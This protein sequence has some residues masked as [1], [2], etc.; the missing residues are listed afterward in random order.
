MV[1]PR[2]ALADVKMKLNDPPNGINLQDLKIDQGQMTFYLTA[3]SKT[4]KVG[5]KDNLIVEAYTEVE[6]TRPDGKK[7][8]IKQQVSLGVLPAIPIEVVK[9]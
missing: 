7:S 3:D 9:P 8:G 5:Y 4:V 2:V 1:P 6:K